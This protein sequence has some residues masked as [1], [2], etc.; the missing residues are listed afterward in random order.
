MHGPAPSWDPSFVDVDVGVSFKPPPPIMVDHPGVNLQQHTQQQPSPSPSSLEAAYFGGT[1][2]HDAHTPAASL[3][4]VPGTATTTTEQGSGGLGSASRA[5]T[6]PSG[7]KIHRRRRTQQHVV[8]PVKVASHTP[9]TA[10]A[11]PPFVPPVMPAAFGP[12]TTTNATPPP[13]SP[14]PPPPQSPPPPPHAWHT[15]VPKT[16]EGVEQ[17]VERWTQKIFEDAE[18][19]PAP[20]SATADTTPH[21]QPTP[22]SARAWEQAAPLRAAAAAAATT[23]TTTDASNDSPAFGVAADLFFQP[24]VSTTTPAPQATTSARRR[25]TAKS[26]SRRSASARRTATTSLREGENASPNGLRIGE[27][28]L[29]PLMK[30]VE[31]TNG[32]QPSAEPEQSPNTIRRGFRRAL[33]PNARDDDTS[34]SPLSFTTTSPPRSARPSM[35]PFK[36]SSS[37]VED[38]ADKHR[39]GNEA[40]RAGDWRAAERLYSDALRSLG[41]DADGVERAT[42]AIYLGNRAAARLMLS[43]PVEALG[44]CVRALALDDTA[45]R[46]RMRLASCLQQLGA[47]V[48]AEAMLRPLLQSVQSSDDEGAAWVRAE[49]RQRAV[50]AGAAD[51]A[52]TRAEAILATCAKALA[53][54][55]VE[56]ESGDVLALGFAWMRKAAAAE[57]AA[58]SGDDDAEEEEEV[59]QPPLTRDDLEARAIEADELLSSAA[60]A[61]PAAERVLVAKVQAALLLRQHAEAAKLVATPNSGGVEY[62]TAL[63]ASPPVVIG[64]GATGVFDPMDAA[65]EAIP[66]HVPSVWRSGFH[67]ISAYLLGQLDEC[68]V[69]ARDPALERAS[70]RAGGQEAGGACFFPALA[71]ECARLQQGREQGNAAFRAQ[72][73]A[74]ALASYTSCLDDNNNFPVPA[75]VAARLLCNRAAVS[76]AT[77]DRVGA[78]R[79]AALASSLDESYSKPLR[80]AAEIYKELRLPALRVE[81]LERLLAIESLEE[82]ALEEAAVELVDARREAEEAALP[83][84]RAAD[85]AASLG[86]TDGEQGADLLAVL[87]VTADATE[88]EV[89]KAYHRLALRCHPDKAA[90]NTAAVL[91]AVVWGRDADEA[92]AAAPQIALAICE[93][94]FRLI[95]TASEALSCKRVEYDSLRLELR[96]SSRRRRHHYSYYNFY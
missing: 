35:S 47:F 54:G 49:A 11:S 57:E 3:L 38:A 41:S 7:R 66:K 21:H 14:P 28:D 86:L 60:S 62:R 67:A 13:Q 51:A 18:A 17:W 8:S 50:A 31:A 34:P 2:N 65:R 46:A 29:S 15:G 92:V 74:Q 32:T 36:T 68:S 96:R 70:R 77:G 78:L 63:R 9:T 33:R 73:H 1:L 59:V 22:F 93:R 23:T 12:T 37:N 48:A 44:D 81:A 4:F 84:R 87:G 53:S 91:R 43:S 85:L 72:S 30:E 20:P 83:P 42:A 52:I 80:R 64:R 79:D 75:S 69:A 5:F 6:S 88:S 45:V 90:R 19:T 26:S 94:G 55:V 56:H 27:V 24:N 16:H 95:K 58:R 82:E 39:R 10:P 61:A 25:H 71:E 89:R 76:H 40:Y